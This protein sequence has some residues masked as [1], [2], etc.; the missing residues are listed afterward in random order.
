MKKAFALLAFI[1]AGIFALASCAGNIE[2]EAKRQLRKT[3]IERYGEQIEIGEIRREYLS[4]SLCCLSVYT[5]RPYQDALDSVAYMP[6]YGNKDS[7][8]V[9]TRHEYVYIDV[10]RQGKRCRKEALWDKGHPRNAKIMTG[11]DPETAKQLEREGYDPLFLS[12]ATL[13][14]IQVAYRDLIEGKY[15]INWNM[16]DY[17][18]RFRFIVAELKV[19]CCGR[20]LE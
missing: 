5:T 12:K 4:D 16:P 1:F 9:T 11:V 20:T 6:Y 18:S 19:R 14:E 13:P 15:H 3:L 8:N 10:V 2:K 7:L 17:E